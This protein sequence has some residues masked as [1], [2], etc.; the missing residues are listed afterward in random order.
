VGVNPW[1]FCSAIVLLKSRIEEQSV[2]LAELP[3]I[4][5]FLDAFF[6]SRIG[7]RI[8]IGQHVSLHEEQRDGYIGAINTQCDPHHLVQ[9]GISYVLQVSHV[10]FSLC[11]QLCHSEL[12]AVNQGVTGMKD[13]QY[14]LAIESCVQAFS[15]GS[16]LVGECRLD[17]D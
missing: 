13:S 16:G 4:H 8:L 12:H 10:H 7:I 15:H 5:S 3:E 1:V 17:H 9:Q 6:L 11:T 14:H 2:S